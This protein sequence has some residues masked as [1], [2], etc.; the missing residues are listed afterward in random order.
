MRYLFQIFRISFFFF[1]VFILCNCCRKSE[2]EK[3]VN[4][5]TK[6]DK[7][8]AVEIGGI[9]LHDNELSTRLK[10]QLIKTGKRVPVLGDFRIEEQKTIFEPL[11]PFTHGL[12]YEILLDDKLFL[13]MEIPVADVTAPELLA[14]Y[15]S[16]DTLP[17]NLL[18]MYFEFTEPMVEG[19]SLAHIT[20]LRSDRDTMKGTF[21]DLQPELW[22]ADGT[23]LTLWL[24][25]GRIKRDLIPNKEL[26]TPLKTNEKYTLLVNKSWKSKNGASLLKSYTKI[27]ITT[28]RDDFSPDPSAWKIHVPSAG[29]KEPLI[30]ILPQPL[31][32]FL[33]KEGITVRKIEGSLVSGVIEIDG[34]ESVVK[35]V[36]SESWPRGSFTLNVESRLE[37]LAGNNLDRP[38]DRDVDDKATV[39]KANQ[40]GQ[41]GFV[42]EFQIP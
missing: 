42:K 35:F 2:E 14:I 20:L 34:K 23:V 38:F 17:E 1:A 10:V 21:L 37:D 12:R 22:N 16:Q 29:G 18:K 33:L 8:V 24:D 26:G 6:D 7:T 32:Y 3:F 36:P 5:V 25:P 11:V 15:P 9:K 28:K 13:E 30:I 41:K 31:D 4:L 27:F 39:G 19:S 40:A